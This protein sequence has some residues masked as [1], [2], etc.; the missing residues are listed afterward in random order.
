MT[1]IVVILT[2]AT[3]AYISYGYITSSNQQLIGEKAR[4]IAKAA[5]INIDGDKFKELTKKMDDKDKYYNELI[6]TLYMIKEETGATFLYTLAQNDDSTYK[7]VADGSDV[8]GGENF[9]SIG[10]EESVEVFDGADK[11]FDGEAVYSEL[12]DADEYGFLLSA[13]VPIKDSNGNIVGVLGCDFSAES[14]LEVSR[15]FK[16]NISIVLIIIGILV[17]IV[18]MLSSYKILSPIDYILKVITEMG[19]GYFSE[20]MDSKLLKRKDEIGIIAKGINNMKESLIILINRIKDES[21]AIKAEVDNVMI[22]ASIL[23]KNLEEI[24]S[25][26]E[27]LSASMEETTAS[28]EEMLATSK[29]IENFILSIAERAKEGALA[30]DKVTKKAEDT[31]KNVIKTQEKAVEIFDDTKQELQKAIK[32][33]KVVNQINV[34]SKSIMEITEQTNLLALNAAIEASRAGEAGKG[35]SVVA[36]EMRKLSEQ[37]KDTVLEIQEITKRVIGCVENLSNSSNSLLEFMAIDVD[38]DYK[39]MLNIT[40]EYSND[41]KFVGKLVSEFSST[42]EKLLDSL[43][44]IVSSIDGVASAANECTG[45]ITDIANRVVDSNNKSNEVANQVMKSKEN[46]EKLKKEVDKFKL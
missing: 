26:T 36:E 11:A 45:G 40:E 34:L 14:V 20:S 18:V 35:F 27:E 29:Q 4:A 38:N 5:V 3:I 23:S 2:V 25:T 13:F 24:S 9:S 16:T 17:N 8:P 12:Y 6:K 37:S 32:E 41:V 15:Q 21:S 43:R 33:S 7:Y 28:S 31:K 42:A 46:A 1:S 19:N 10:L 39:K 44:D 30:V 22:N